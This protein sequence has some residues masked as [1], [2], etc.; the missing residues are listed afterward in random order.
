MINQVCWQ[1]ISNKILPCEE[2]EK[3]ELN[4]NKSVVLRTITHKLWHK[5]LSLPFLSFQV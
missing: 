1:F 2:K 3:E 4:P 5:Q